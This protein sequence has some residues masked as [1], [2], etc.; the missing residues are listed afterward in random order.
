MNEMKQ[1]FY[2]Y[3]TTPI[4][5]IL[6]FVNIPKRIEIEKRQRKIALD[7]KCQ[8]IEITSKL[9]LEQD[10]QEHMAKG[11]A[12]HPLF[13]PLLIAKKIE[14][15]EQMFYEKKKNGDFDELNI[16]LK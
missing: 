12:P 10:I 11:E 7:N 15:A 16:L 2:K 1:S 3:V 4:A 13:L 8:Y 9:L 6:D 5:K 14:E